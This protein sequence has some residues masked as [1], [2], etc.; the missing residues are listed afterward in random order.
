ML[1]RTMGV[2]AVTWREGTE[3]EEQWGKAHA[4]GECPGKGQG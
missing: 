4:L 1:I 3:A 2:D